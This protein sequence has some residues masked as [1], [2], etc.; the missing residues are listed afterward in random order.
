MGSD[1]SYDKDVIHHSLCLPWAGG[2]AGK[3]TAVVSSAAPIACVLT[4]KQPCCQGSL[5]VGKCVIEYII[6]KII[7]RLTN[8]SLHYDIPLTK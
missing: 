7:L 3:H 4:R 2:S 6:G 5:V 8:I 1:Q